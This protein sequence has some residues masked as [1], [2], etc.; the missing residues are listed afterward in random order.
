[1]E[2]ANKTSKFK[3]LK[4][5]TSEANQIKRLMIH[6][7]TPVPKQ[8]I[9]SKA[10]TSAR[11]DSAMIDKATRAFMM[12]H[13]PKVR[14]A[15][16]LQTRLVVRRGAHLSEQ[17]WIDLQEDFHRFLSRLNY[18]IFGNLNRRKPTR[19][20][21][22]SLP[23]IEGRQFSPEGRRT[24]HYHVAFGNIPSQNSIYKF[25]DLVHEEWAQTKYGKMDIV[26]TPM[27]VGWLD[28]I[29]KELETGNVECVD[30]RNTLAPR[31]VL[32]T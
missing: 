21:L 2:E 26:V 28:Y 29:T 7:R 10:M 8:E 17:Q 19:Y 22:L 11:L 32:S 15:L 16:T 5:L 20:S 27:D 13:G 23:V 4:K 14:L 12:K 24:L 1:M 3:T 6:A 25:L 30:W 31:H 9:K 18:R